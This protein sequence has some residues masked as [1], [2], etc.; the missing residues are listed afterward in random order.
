[1][2][3]NPEK[4]AEELKKKGISKPKVAK[5][6]NKTERA[7]SNIR[8]VRTNLSYDTSKM[9]KVNYDLLT[10]ALEYLDKQ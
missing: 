7:I 2:A 4:K 10:E 5:A 1:M 9:G 8:R 3:I 6:F